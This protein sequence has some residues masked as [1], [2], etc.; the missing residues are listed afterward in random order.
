[1]VLCLV[2]SI[3]VQGI[4]LVTEGRNNAIPLVHAGRNMGFL[5]GRGKALVVICATERLSLLILLSAECR[6]AVLCFVIIV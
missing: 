5:K 6:H 1:M 3:T 2:G 4:P